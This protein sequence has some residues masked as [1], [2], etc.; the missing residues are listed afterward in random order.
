MD[1]LRE[2]EEL[3]VRRAQEGPGVLSGRVARPDG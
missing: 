2:C 1:Q 3:S